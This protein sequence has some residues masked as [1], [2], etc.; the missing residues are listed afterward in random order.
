MPI[1]V[2][3]CSSCGAEVEKLQPSFRSA[4]PDCEAGRP[5]CFGSPMERIPAASN[6]QLGTGKKGSP[7]AEAI[8][9]VKMLPPEPGGRTGR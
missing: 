8:K 4:P 1:Y 5:A 6:Y 7:T 2:Y 3:R 9:R